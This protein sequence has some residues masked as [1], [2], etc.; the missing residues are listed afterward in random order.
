MKK[1][2]KWTPKDLIKS[3]GTAEY[4]NNELSYTVSTDFGFSGA[5]I[6]LVNKG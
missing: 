2:I 5:P 1:W 6:V 3:S 4:Y